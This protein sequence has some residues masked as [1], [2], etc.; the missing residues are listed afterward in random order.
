MNLHRIGRLRL[1]RIVHAVMNLVGACLA[2][3]ALAD[4]PARVTPDQSLDNRDLLKQIHARIVA[5]ES[6]A[7]IG[8]HS[9]T[10]PQTDI[11]FDMVA[12]PGGVFRMGSPIDEADRQA[13]EGPAASVRV[14]PFW[15]GRCEVTWDEYEPF[16]ISG[17]AR[18]KHG[19]WK[20]YVPGE[21][22]L[23]DGVSQPTA[24]YT[25][26]SFGMGQQGYPAICMTQ[27]AANKYCQWLSAQLGHFY[28]LPTEAEWE[29]A[30]RAGSDSPFG[31]NSD[32]L[33]DHAWY[34]DNSDDRYHLVGTK[35][36]NAWGLHD[37]HGNVLE[38]VA[39][40]YAEDY[41]ERIG[42]RPEDPLVLAER[43]YPRSVRGGSWYDDPDQ[44]RSAYRRGSQKDWKAQDPQLPRSVWYHT[45]APWLGF[46]V[47]RPFRIPTVDE[48]DRAWNSATDAR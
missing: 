43:L 44:L 25:E 35:K 7:E 37:M 2:V 24:P 15:M 28:R 1:L 30:C 13:N 20:D 17:L 39:D 8:D 4:G 9:V 14:S 27:H 12:I 40:G 10:I 48:M 46:R 23:V 19:G 3:N 36:P 31:C 38:W 33:G 47:V 32:E 16:M 6:A 45:D 22:S 11:S 41:F 29:Y 34:Y 42:A 21:H 18:E 26:M 5:T